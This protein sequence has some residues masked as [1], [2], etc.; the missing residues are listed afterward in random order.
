MTDVLDAKVVEGWEAG[1]AL[2]RGGEPEDVA[3]ACLVLASDASAYITGQLL[4]ADG[5]I[6]QNPETYGLKPAPNGVCLRSCLYLCP[7][8]PSINVF[9]RSKAK[10][11]LMRSRLRYFNIRHT[12]THFIARTSHI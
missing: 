8:I 12:T 3:N 7:S 5:G 6:L 10:T 11:T 4:T 9:S 2:K 1:I